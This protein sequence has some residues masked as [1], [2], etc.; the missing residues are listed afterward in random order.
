MPVSHNL[1]SPHA[2]ISQLA[3]TTDAFS[4]RTIKTIPLPHNTLSPQSPIHHRHH[5]DLTIEY[6]HRPLSHNYNLTIHRRQKK[7]FHPTA[8]FHNKPLSGNPPYS[9]ILQLSK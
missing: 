1:L 9:F 2:S 4:Q 3:V 5:N 7:K 8:P 6:H